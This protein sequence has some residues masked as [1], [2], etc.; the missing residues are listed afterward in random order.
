MRPSLYHRHDLCLFLRR[1]S[2]GNHSNISGGESH[3]QSPDCVLANFEAGNNDSTPEQERVASVVANP[4]T[5][6]FIE[7]RVAE[8]MDSAAAQSSV[9]H[10]NSGPLSSR[11]RSR[12][13]SEH[14]DFSLPAPVV[15]ENTEA[16]LEALRSS[17][18]VGGVRVKIEDLEVELPRSE[19]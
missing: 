18:A 7:P 19:W 10:R 8:M 5:E 14:A 13:V 3:P 6:E 17:P 9:T 12:G 2:H 1:R 11:K 4:A 16:Q 15:K